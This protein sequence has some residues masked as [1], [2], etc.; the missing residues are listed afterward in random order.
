MNRVSKVLS[1]A[2]VGFDSHLVEVEGD[3]KNGLPNLQ[4]VGL[5]N[6]AIDEAKERVRSAIINS[7]LDYPASKLT[8]NL[9][10]AE[11]PKVGSHYDLPIALAIL[12]SAGQLRQT[13][14]GDAVFA[15]E[16]ALDGLVRPISGAI[17]IAEA[18]RNYHKKRLYIPC[19]NVPQTLLVDDVEIIGV[20]SLKE[21]YLHLKG[22]INL[23]IADHR[24]TITTGSPHEGP[25]L[26]EI[27]GQET[28]KRALTIAIAGRHNILLSG[29]P[30]AGKTLLAKTI[31]GLMPELTRQEQLETTKLHSIAGELIDDIIKSRPFRSPHHSASATS[32]VGGGSKPRPGEISLAHNGVLFL[33]EIPEYPRSILESLRQPLEDRVVTIARASGH[34]IFPANFMLVATMNPCP[35]GYYGDPE[36]ECSCTTNQ[37]LLYQKKLSGPLMDR[38]DMVI[39]LSRVPHKRLLS[40]SNDTNLQQNTNK[41]VINKAIEIQTNRYKSSNKYNGDLT[42]KEISRHAGLDQNTKDFLNDA[43]KKLNLSARSYFKLLKVARTIADIAGERSIKVSHIAEAIQYRYAS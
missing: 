43:A 16:L 22:E 34:S 18:T 32:I 12:V 3:S 23:P 14:V 15:G 10:P 35:C 8:I 42:S 13:D 33:D 41:E 24:L 39:N 27:Y 29:P 31:P 2:S 25:T 1:V 30:G 19:Q 38:I 5:G 4:I 40:Q 6:K 11:L 36:K 26:D 28:A 17:N 21:L 37:I 9:A 20:T 7:N